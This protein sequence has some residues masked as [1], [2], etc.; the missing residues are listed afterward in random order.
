MKKLLFIAVLFFFAFPTKAQ[1]LNFDETVKYIKDKMECC[2]EYTKST[3]EIKKN[4]LILLTKENGKKYNFN[5][6]D[7]Y[8]GVRDYPKVAISG[9]E[10]GF[11]YSKDNSGI[12]FILSANTNVSIHF[13]TEDD[14]LRV[15]K[16]FR[17]LLTLCTKQKD[18]FDD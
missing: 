2:Q 3:I 18:P 12:F 9:E 11:G 4:G 15:V 7:L 10:N 13:I 8:K 14:N 6:F 17:R 16:A 1:E 5:L